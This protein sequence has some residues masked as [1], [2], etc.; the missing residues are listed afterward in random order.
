MIHIVFGNLDAW[1]LG[2]HHGVSSAHLQGYLNEFVFR[3]NRRFWPMVGFDSVLKIA[4]QVEGPTYKDF[5]EDKQ[6]AGNTT[7]ACDLF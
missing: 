4:A 7:Q 1:L 6:S 2:T 5:Y 3:F